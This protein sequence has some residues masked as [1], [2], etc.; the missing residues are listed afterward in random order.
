M[1][2]KYEYSLKRKP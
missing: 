2:E 1:L